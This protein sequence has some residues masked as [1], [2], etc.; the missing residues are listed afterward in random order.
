M[1][2]ITSARPSGSNILVASSKIIISGRKA[3]TPAIATRCFG[4]QIAEQVL[5]WQNLTYEPVLMHR[6]HVRPFH[7]A[8][9]LDFLNQKPHRLRLLNR[10]I[11]YL[12]S[13]NHSYHT[14]DIPDVC[15]I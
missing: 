13:E 10:Q 5:A 11:G 12:D 1:V 3:T 2:A 15:F 14:P 7:H 6:E 8:E 4:R 9:Y